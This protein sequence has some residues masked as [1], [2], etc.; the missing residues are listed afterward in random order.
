MTI[1]PGVPGISTLVLRLEAANWMAALRL[2]L[3]QIADEAARNGRLICEVMAD[4]SVLARLASTGA[5][6]HIKKISEMTDSGLVASVLEASEG[7]GANRTLLMEEAQPASPPPRTEGVRSGGPVTGG[8]PRPN[9]LSDSSGHHP[10]MVFRKSDIE[11]RLRLLGEC[12]SA[13]PESKPAEN[14]P[15]RDQPVRCI[16]VVDVERKQ[17]DGL[18][19]IQSDLDEVRNAAFARSGQLPD[20]FRAPSGFEWVEDLLNGVLANSE[21]LSETA[22][23]LLRISLAAIPSKSALL[24]VSGPKERLGVIASVGVE[25]MVQGR[26]EVPLMG[27]LLQSLVRHN[28]SVVLDSTSQAPRSL[29][30]LR[31]DLGVRAACAM[32]ASLTSGKDSMGLLILIDSALGPHYATQDLAVATYLAARICGVVRHLS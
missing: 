13:R 9:R 22:N 31:A 23:R 5:T 2:G 25:S 12:G 6:Y 3:A 24:L 20:S 8:T 18:S 10:C 17:K 1:P 32:L 19:T 11:E 14:L 27:G 29:S 28:L 30:E 16:P 21:G 26:G 4:G 7:Y 15:G